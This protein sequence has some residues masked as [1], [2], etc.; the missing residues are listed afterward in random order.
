MSTFILPTHQHLVRTSFADLAGAA[1]RFAVALFAA[2][3]RQYV[4]QEVV[5]PTGPS[6]RTLQRTRSS[7]VAMANRCESHSPSMAAELRNLASRG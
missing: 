3:E 5:Q 7:L 1:R 2:Q 6:E 4:P